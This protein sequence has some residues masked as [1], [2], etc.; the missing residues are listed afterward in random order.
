MNKGYSNVYESAIY[1]DFLINWNQFYIFTANVLY[2]DFVTDYSNQY[3]VVVT[4]KTISS[5]FLLRIYLN[6]HH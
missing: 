2:N 6:N 5:M 4:N 1:A 3:Q